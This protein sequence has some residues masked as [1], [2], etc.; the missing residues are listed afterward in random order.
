MITNITL[1]VP[2]LPSSQTA[3]SPALK[4]FAPILPP[5]PLVVVPPNSPE[6][7]AA[8]RPLLPSFSGLIKANKKARQDEKSVFGDILETISVEDWLD[9]WVDQPRKKERSSCGS[10]LAA[11]G[12]EESQHASS[13]FDDRPIGYI[14]TAMEKKKVAEKEKKIKPSK[15]VDEDVGEDVPPLRRKTEK[16][17]DAG[18]SEDPKVRIAAL[19]ISLLS[20]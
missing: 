8:S 1:I 7:E 15:A 13:D 2:D 19:L 20:A 17:K 10:V 14:I 6:L 5:Q 16:S 4:S 9:G 11:S 18:T 12:L 3:P